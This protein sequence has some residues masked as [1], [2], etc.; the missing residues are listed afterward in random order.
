MLDLKNNELW[1]SFARSSQCEQDFPAQLVKKISPFQQV[2]GV[3]L[4]K[5]LV[6]MQWLS[7]VEISIS[8]IQVNVGQGVGQGHL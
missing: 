7:V 8:A 5:N 1:S 3:I 4:S 2:R 6:D